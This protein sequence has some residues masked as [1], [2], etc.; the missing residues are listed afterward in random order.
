MNKKIWFVFVIIVSLAQLL[1]PLSQAVAE[2]PDPDPVHALQ[3][4]ALAQAVQTGQDTDP[5]HAAWVNTYTNTQPK[6][7][8]KSIAVTP[9]PAP[10]PAPVI[11]TLTT[12]TAGY[13]VDPNSA[14]KQQADAWRVARPADAAKMDVLAAQP[15]AKWFGDWSGD[16]QSAVN[17][18]VS[19]AA[20]AGK[21]ALIVAYDIP[22]R[23]CGGY[24][25]GGNGDYSAWVKGLAQGIGSRQAT[26]ILE[27]DSLALV[28]CLSTSDL[29][30]RYQLLSSAVSVLKNNSNTKVYLDAGHSA[31]VDPTTM[32]AR[33][34][35][36]NVAQADGFYTNVSN[37][38]TTSDETVYGANVSQLLGGKHFVVDTSRNGNGSN[39]EWCN[40]T[41]RAIGQTP[42]NQTGNALVDALLWVKTP[43]ESDGTCNGG[44]SAGV[45]WPDY[46]LSLV[47]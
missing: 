13:Y 3:M 28:D 30:T 38:M 47:P 26:V 22:Q 43:G 4:Q 12:N 44:P 40:P 1:I 7:N 46:A 34:Q 15:T 27:P 39:G 37:F 14:A 8:K 23:D 19:Q 35:K 6:S 25:A 16:I 10:T 29:N 45:W 31:W 42:T 24:S 20:A 11:T 5:V 9:P 41:G 17:S 2:T 18:Y 33:L 21:E 36:A 32:A